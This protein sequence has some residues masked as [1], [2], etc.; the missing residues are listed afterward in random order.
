MEKKGVSKKRIVIAAVVAVLAVVALVFFL[1]RGKGDA[2][3]SIQIYDLKGS[4]TISRDGVGYMKAS[5]KLFLQSGDK[6]SVDADS[7]MRLKLDDDKYIMVEENSVLSMEAEGTKEDSKTRIALEKGAVTSEIQNKLNSKSSYEVSTPNSVMAVR[8]TVFR[9]EVTRDE[10]GNIYTKLTT[11]DGKVGSRL[12]NG[13]GTYSEDE[14][15]VEAGEE[16]TAYGT[17]EESQYMGEPSDIDYSQL[18]VEV[19]KYIKE[20]IESG[21][22]VT[23][24]TLDE[25]NQLIQEKEGESEQTDTEQADTYTV[26]FLANGSVFGKQ[27]VGAGETVTAP[28]LAPSE[29]GSWKFDFSTKINQ[30]TNIEWK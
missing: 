7:S 14:V 2:Y 25:L 29:T 30:D 22:T 15:L 8:G 6:V 3:R 19:L 5:E 23:G 13:D 24:T 4:A 12:S 20:I 21:R 28:K 11:F 17:I 18:P 16:I 27:E 26:T 10:N 1:N 9:V